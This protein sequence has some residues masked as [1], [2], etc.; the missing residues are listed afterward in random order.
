MSKNEFHK[1]LKKRIEEITPLKSNLLT[2]IKEYVNSLEEIPDIQ[3][4]IEHVLRK[5]RQD[6]I[7]TTNQLRDFFKNI[8]PIRDELSKCPQQ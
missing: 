7:A 3:I 2:N 4:A 1:E 8:P 6:R 5:E